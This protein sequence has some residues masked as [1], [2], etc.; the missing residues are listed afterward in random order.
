MTEGLSIGDVAERT[1]LAAG[2]IRM[3]E[4]R[5]G[6]PTPRRLPSGYRVYGVGDVDLLRRA[7]AY[8]ERGLSVGAALERAR[9]NGTET[10]LPSIYGAVAS[11]VGAPRTH[12]L[13]KPSLLAISRAIED[14]TLA[15]A[16]APLCFGAFQEERFYRRV[17]HRYRRIADSADATVVFA[18][19]PAVREAP[20]EP[21]EIPIRGEAALGNEWAVIIDAPGYA[22][23]LLAWEHPNGVERDGPDDAERRFEAIWTIDP[24]AVRRASLVSARL[25]AREDAELGRRLDALLADRRLAIETPAPALTALTNR[26]VG[27]LEEAA[28]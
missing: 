9:E 7:L 24:D 18:D 22:A 26:M 5:Y 15:H 11:A 19:F 12:L 25:A 6:A 2:T 23:C 20:G 4:Q 14:E 28:A 3:W 8:R 21:S 27:Y 1:G 16:A 10:D 13:R 17:E